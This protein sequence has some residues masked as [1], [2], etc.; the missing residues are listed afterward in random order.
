MLRN[1]YL[2][3]DDYEVVVLDFDLSWHKGALQGSVSF[4]G[5][6]H[7]YLAPEQLRDIEGLPARNATV[8]S[9]GLGMTLLFMATGHDPMPN[10]QLTRNWEQVIRN[11]ILSATPPLGWRSLPARFARLIADA[12]RDEPLD[13]WTL[14]QISSDLQLMQ[15]AAQGNCSSAELWAEELLWRCKPECQYTYSHEGFVHHTAS[16]VRVVLCGNEVE[17]TIY[18]TLDWSAQGYE[19]RTTLV[20]F[21]TERAPAVRSLLADGGWQVVDVN[22]SARELRIIAQV[23][24]SIM[25]KS[26]E[27]VSRA[28]SRALDRMSFA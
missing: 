4:T 17:D 13:R 6:K 24:V 2:P 15:Q 14:M 18:L 20:K 26:I 21:I 9:F 25:P 7:G 22:Q 12:T 28:L 3:K 1:F 23:T 5:E 8:D 16:H 19:D 11:R 27:Q 10:E